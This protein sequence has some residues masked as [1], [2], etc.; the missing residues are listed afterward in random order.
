ML[1]TFALLGEALTGVGALVS[2]LY[3]TIEFQKSARAVRASAFQQVVN[4]FASFS[5]DTARSPELVD[6]WVRAAE[7]FDS[8]TELERA[9]YSLLILSLLRRA[10]N[11]FVQDALHNL[12]EEHWSGIRQSII[13]MMSTSGARAC[14]AVLKGRLNPQFRNFF[15]ELIA[16]DAQSGGAPAPPKPSESVGVPREAGP[17]TIPE[18]S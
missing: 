17:M 12:D 7:D 14:W 11:V 4:S 9:Q 18:Q 16:S 6:L 15:D 8:L 13:L 10:E 5:F 3:L 2:I 1:E